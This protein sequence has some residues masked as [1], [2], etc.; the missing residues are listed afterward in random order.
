MARHSL[1]NKRFRLV[2][3]QK[4]TEERV[5]RSLNLVPR[6][7]LGNCRETLATQ[8]TSTLTEGVLPFLNHPIIIQRT[9]RLPWLVL[10]LVGISF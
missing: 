6:S 10:L 7:L 3:E 9:E 4:K 2:L 5:S 8:A 1:S